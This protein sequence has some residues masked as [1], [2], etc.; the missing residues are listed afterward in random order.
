MELYQK[1]QLLFCN[2]ENSSQAEQNPFAGIE[3]A[4]E[5]LRGVTTTP[6]GITEGT[7]L[8]VQM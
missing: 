7:A 1:V 6:A 2:I 4:P 8:A 3:T 5:L